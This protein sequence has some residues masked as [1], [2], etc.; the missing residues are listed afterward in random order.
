[1]KSAKSNHFTYLPRYMN[2]SDLTY[3]FAVHMIS[4]KSSLELDI[5]IMPK[6]FFFSCE[7]LECLFYNNRRIHNRYSKRIYEEFHCHLLWP[8]WCFSRDNSM[9][10][11]ECF[12]NSVWKSSRWQQNSSRIQ[13]EKTN[14]LS[15]C[16]NSDIIVYWM[17]LGLKKSNSRWQ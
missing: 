7:L 4:P 15:D 9:S 1:M 10:S 3:L 6:V 8:S 2:S 12:R 17:T 16:Y 14:I 11:A 13:V 5:L